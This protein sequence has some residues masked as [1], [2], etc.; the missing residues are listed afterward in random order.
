MLLNTYEKVTKL[1]RDGNG[2]R[3][4]AQLK[5]AKV[6]TVQIKELVNKGILE[7][8]SHGHYWLIDEEKGKPENFE[9]LEACMV[10]PRAVICA[11]SACYYHGL[12]EKA[13]EKLSVA[14]LKT[15]RSKMQL[16]FPVTR[17]YYSD[18]AFEQDMEVVDTPYGQIR[19][20]ALERSV[21]DTIRFRADIGVEMVEHIVRN[22][23]KRE[24][25][26]MERLLAY[27]DAMRVGKIVRTTLGEKE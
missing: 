25:R 4:A 22:Y 12:V 3:N 14:T 26:Q 2:Y 27:A 24:N 21:C 15:D 8:V 23:M 11:D 20:Y 16:N 7:R 17:H 6:T 13:P 18:L 1:F 9:M 10:N 5:D 19:I